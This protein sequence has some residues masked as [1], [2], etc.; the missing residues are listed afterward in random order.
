MKKDLQLKLFEASKLEA[1]SDNVDTKKISKEIIIKLDS[2]DLD[3]YIN[4]VQYLGLEQTWNDICTYALIFGE[5]S[6]FIKVSNF[7]EMYEI[8]LATVD[9]IKE[10][11][12]QG[13][14][15]YKYMMEKELKI[16]IVFLS[17]KA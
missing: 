2:Y 3:K 1:S 11:E 5:R 16:K 6:N 10:Y 13:K 15:S 17:D 7:G 4:D 14:W 9:K 8:G 12:F